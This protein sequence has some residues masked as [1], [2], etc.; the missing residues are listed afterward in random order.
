MDLSHIIFT[1]LASG[2]YAIIIYEI[3]IRYMLVKDTLAGFGIFNKWLVLA[4][5]LFTFGFIKHEIG[6]YLTIESNY[7]KQTNVCESALLKSSPGLFDKLKSGLGF[8]ENI[9][10]EN[11]GEGFIFVLVGTPIFL[12]IRNKLFA[13][14]MTGVVADLVSEYSG[15]HRYFCRTSCNVNPLSNS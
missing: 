9:W 4:G 6:Y 2:I 1:S 10:F 11:I 8:L 12:G 14:F 5:I 13:A 3:V 7:C 15:I